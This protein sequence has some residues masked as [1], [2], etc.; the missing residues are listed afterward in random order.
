[1]AEQSSIAAD[2]ASTSRRSARI[3]EPTP[4]DI[5]TRILRQPGGRLVILKSATSPAS[6]QRL[7]TQART[8]DAARHPGVVEL[9]D[10]EVS[11]DSITLTIAWAGSRRLSDIPS[12]DPA[13]IAGL[14]AAIAGIIADLHDIGVVH[15]RIDASHVVIDGNGAPVL[16][17]F[18]DPAASS[19]ADDVAAIGEMVHELLER[20]ARPRPVFSLRHRRGSA[21]TGGLLHLIGAATDPD[22]RRRPTARTLA[23]T[24]HRAVGSPRLPEGR[25]PG[26]DPNGEAGS[27]SRSGSGRTPVGSIVD[28]GDS[29]TD[30]FRELDT[31][32]DTN[33]H[34]R[35]TRQ[36]A[37]TAS[38]V[39]V[40]LVVIL[41]PRMIG[42]LF[43]GSRPST[44]PAP[45]ASAT[46]VF[47]SHA[48]GSRTVGSD[49][50]AD[51]LET[52]EPSAVRANAPVVEHDGV[53]FR[54]G[55]P[56]DLALVAD[57]YCTG[58][59]TP[60]VI[61]P[62][63]LEVFVFDTWAT[64]ATPVATTSSVRL[65]DG[66]DVE[67]ATA[68]PGRCG[69]LLVSRIAGPAIAVSVVNAS[70]SSFGTEAGQ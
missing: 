67:T 48:D 45:V 17:G 30:V 51:G 43:D 16:C 65:P 12:L 49:T 22:P 34:R 5:V 57:W 13:E 58:T 20:S 6:I 63:T 33:K 15:G 64:D 54:V 66:V 39:V 55:E 21:G 37:K 41:G 50:V 59:V 38:L 53:L 28:P 36:R 29:Y 69:T 4:T 35:H 62:R 9:L 26:G 47:G 3:P 42:S 60:A 19:S 52:S 61:R 24:A 68:D 44:G 25:S 31:I 14:T 40:A 32:L 8:L 27:D 10:T 18:G 11:T 7:L 23:A 2:T 70:S 56:G 46:D 1:M